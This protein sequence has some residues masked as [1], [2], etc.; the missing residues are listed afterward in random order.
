MTPRPGYA[1]VTP[2]RNELENLE[3]LAACVV[4]Q[5]LEPVAWIIVDDAS[6]D[7]TGELAAALAAEHEPDAQQ[8]GALAEA[9]AER[10]PRAHV[11]TRWL[12]EDAPDGADT[13][14][15]TPAGPG[16]LVLCT[17]GLWNVLHGAAELAQLVASAG[18]R[19]PLGL[20][21]RLVSTAIGRGGPDN[22]TVAV[23]DVEPGGH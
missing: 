16:R 20:A 22:V 4:A 2:A 10:D 6:D 15:W 14:R 13:S 9:A 11:I 3:R 7:G 1:L 5:E 17:D 8:H 23:V 21:R 18:D 19:S 12:G